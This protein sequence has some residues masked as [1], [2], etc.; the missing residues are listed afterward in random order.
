MLN[1]Y[2]IINFWLS[3]MHLNT[4]EIFLEV[5]KLQ[6]FSK[7]A[8]QIGMTGAAVSKQVMALEEELGVKLLH[9]TTRMVSLTTEGAIYYE[10]ARLALEELKDAAAQIQAAKALPRGTLRINAPLS[11]GQMHLLPVL[12]GFAQKYPELTLEVS[13]DDRMVDVLA[14]GYDLVIRVGVPQDSTLISR[15][16]G[17]CPIITVASPA[18]IAAHGSP[19][20]PQHLKLHRTIAYTHQGGASEWRYE[21]KKGAISSY[22]SEGSFRANTADMMLQAAL[23]GIGIACL[24]CFCVN[25]HLKAG[26][27]V[28]VLP[29]YEITPLRHITALMPPSRY[30]SAKVKL[31]VEWLLE[32]CKAMPF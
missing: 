20:T 32:A 4:V 17:E 14:E 27:L 9:R 18:Y 28:R 2:F 3:I 15:H 5:A 12:S 1:N 23:D 7:A 11:Y 22:R 13:L 25:M 26:Q 19:E 16:L 21:D 10:R 6:S 31:F 24:P 8:R 30:R 29:D